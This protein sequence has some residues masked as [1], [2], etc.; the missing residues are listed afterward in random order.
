MINNAQP[1]YACPKHMKTRW[2]SP[3]N[4]TGEKGAA[5]TVGKGRKGAPY[6]A[7]P[8]G[9]SRVLAEVTGTSGMIRR[10][11]ATLDVR[12][13]EMLRGLKIEIFWDGAK[14]P[15]VSAPW[16]DF[17]GQGLGQ[18]IQFDSALFSNPEGRSFNCSVPMPFRT[19]M[20]VVATNESVKPLNLF[21]FDIDYTLGDKHPEDMGYFHA[22]WRRESPTTIRQDFE[23]LPKVSGCGRFLGVNVS[24]IPDRHR[25]GWAWWGEG[26]FKAF[27]DGDKDQPTLCGTGTEDY[28]G[29]AWGQGQYAQLYQGCHLMY[30]DQFQYAFYRYHV[31]DPVYFQ[32]D[33]R[34]C[35]Q[36]I[37]CTDPAGFARMQELGVKELF[38]AGLNQSPE[39]MER[40]IKIEELAKSASYTLFERQDDWASCAYFYLDKPENGLP[41]L[42]PAAERIA[43]CVAQSDATKRTDV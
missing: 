37:G 13:P 27:I 25:Y 7:L 19:G 3:E 4:W 31:N 39:R 43:G 22:H 5:A 34:V 15:A 36:Q 26:E 10:M 33:I 23:F 9:E 41:P 20:K 2:A 38:V 18:C 14:T 21:F 29:T 8:V 28:I 42:Q 6:F 12:G 16:G 24:V 17:F 11:W 35:M 32:E 30:S 40:P 1:L